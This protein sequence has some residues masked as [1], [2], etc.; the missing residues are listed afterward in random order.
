MNEQ[1]YQKEVMDQLKQQ[2][3]NKFNIKPSDMIKFHNWNMK[4]KNESKLV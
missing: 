1:Q 2:D 3:E 4:G